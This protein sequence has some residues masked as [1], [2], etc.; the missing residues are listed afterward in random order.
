MEDSAQQ[1]R[2]WL[3]GLAR[4]DGQVFDAVYARYRPGVFAFLAR[5]TGRREVAEDL[6]QEV[7]LRLARSGAS[8]APG[9]DL[10]AWL[11]TVASNA[12]RSHRRWQVV[13]FERVRQAL[14]VPKA[15]QVS[16]FEAVSATQ[17][18]RT[19]ERALNALSPTDR[20]LLLLV[21]VE[22][23]TPAQA[24]TALKVTP[25]TLRQR[26]SRARARLLTQVDDPELVSALGGLS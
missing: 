19:L 11:F 16:P 5:M 12:A 3:D 15:Q 24:S 13:D 22:G 21:G 1:Q 26:L 18:Q 14:F 6:L 17:A 25:E 9:T 10:G 23:L 8:L 20:E 4:G 7:W 2:E